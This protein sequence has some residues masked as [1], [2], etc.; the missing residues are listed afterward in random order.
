MILDL[1]SLQSDKSKITAEIWA[2][3]AT[4]PAEDLRSPGTTT[5]SCHDHDLLLRP[6]SPVTTTISCYDD[7]LPSRGPNTSTASTS[8]AT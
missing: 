5:I 6:R 1:A 2:V 3:S 7:D 4:C 8:L